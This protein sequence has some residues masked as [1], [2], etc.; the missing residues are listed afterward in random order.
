MIRYNRRNTIWL[1]ALSLLMLLV[2]LSGNVAGEVQAFFTGLFLLAVV[3]T[4]IDFSA[5]KPGSLMQSIQQRSPLSRMSPEA[6]EAIAR[7]SARPGYYAPDIQMADIGLIALQSGDGMVMRRARSISKDDDGVRPFVTLNVPSSEA[8]RHANILFEI[9]DQNGDEQYVYEMRVYL[10]D[11]EVNILAD[12]QLPLAGNDHI[13]GMGDWDLRVSV[14][15]S[16][17]G[18]HSFGLTASQDTR[19]RRLGGRAQQRYVTHSEPEA[20]EEPGPMTLEELL[21]KQDRG[22]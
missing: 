22:K 12:T 19:I 17:V 21:R 14:D 10:R 4:F 16:L 6:R 2:L 11:G 5:L 18:I 13:A 1:G 15:G 20:A 8:E 7:A 3:A 9:I